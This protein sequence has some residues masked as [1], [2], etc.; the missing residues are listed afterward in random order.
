[1]LCR[2]GHSLGGHNALFVAVFEPRIKVI[3]SSCGWTPF[4][5]YYGGKLKGWTSDRY[6]PLLESRYGLDPDLVPF[7]FY[8][9]IAALAPRPFLS[10]SPLHDSNFDVGGVRKAITEAGKVYRLLGAEDRLRVEHPES[11]HDFIPVMREESY[12]F[13]AEWL[14]FR[15]PEPLQLP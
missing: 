1:M 5:D 9:V 7:D 6:I 14:D 15:L 4:H 11:E 8:E 10:I 12:R 13:L 3:V 2:S